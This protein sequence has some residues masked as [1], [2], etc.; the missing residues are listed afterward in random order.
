MCKDCTVF[1][2]EACSFQHILLAL[3][4]L[5]K[6]VQRRREGSAASR[7]PWKNLNGDTT[8]VFRA[9]VAEGVSTQVEVLS[10]SDAESMWNILATSIKEAAKNTLGVAIGSSKTHTARRESWWLCEEVQSKVTAKQARFRE[11][12]SC[13]E[14][15]QDDRL[16]VQERYKEAKKVAKKAVAQAKE[17]AYEQLYKN[18]DSKEGAND[19]FRIAKARARRRRDLGDICFIKDEEGR[20]ITDG[21]KIKKRWGEYFSSLLNTREPEGHEE[22]V[23]PNIR[24]QFDCY[25][26]RINKAE[27]R[28]SLQKMGRN[29]AVGMDQIPIES[30][31]SLRDKGIFWL[32]SLFDKIFTSVKMLEEWRLSDVIPSFKNKGDA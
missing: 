5:F 25:Y 8:E 21:E 28:I 20:S 10:T 32:T 26:S 2:R 23:D 14:G 6:S 11:L 24:S 16:R 18:L 7:I 13:R 12:L 31:R 29:K 4:T 22:V 1:P 19:I 3:N 15:D 17:K 30:W 27:V 9:R